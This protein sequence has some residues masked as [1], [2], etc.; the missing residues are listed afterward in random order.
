MI[1]PHNR[2]VL[3][4]EKLMLR[5]P[6]EADIDARFAL[7]SHPEIL[8]MFGVDPKAV[9]PLEPQMAK[10]WVNN[11]LEAPL[12]FM[13]VLNGRLI[14]DVRLHSIFTHDKRASVAISLLD[15]DLL[16]KGYG[17][18]AMSLLLDHAFHTMRLNRISLRVIE[19]NDR[20]IACYKKLGFKEEGRRPAL[21]RPTTMT[22]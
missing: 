22:S 15:P 16:G 14:G 7:G 5:A 21:A 8:R 11:N 17:T 13:I 20:A 12:A 10:S 6:I 3:G 4:D 9:Q 19:F 2:P 18:A 1:D